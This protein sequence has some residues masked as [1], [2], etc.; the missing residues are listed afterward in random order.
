MPPLN[1]R[2]IPP[3]IYQQYAP[4]VTEAAKANNIRE[5]IV[6]A[7]M[8]IESNFDVKARSPAGA[9]G[10]MQLL[11]QTAKELGCDDPFDGHANIRA[12]V[13]YLKQLSLIYKGCL[14]Y[15][16]AAYNWGPGNLGTPPK[17]SGIWPRETQ[18]YLVNFINAYGRLTGVLS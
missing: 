2:L 3:A 1:V 7:V 13:K 8:A 5:E 17:P 6:W 14:S 11:P 18:K 4:T 9:C 15:M 10:L 16:L 12:G